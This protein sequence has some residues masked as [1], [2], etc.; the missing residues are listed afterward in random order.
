MEKQ[1]GFALRGEWAEVVGLGGPVLGDFGDV[2]I[3]V[4]VGIG[5]EFDPLAGGIPPDVEV[6]TAAVGAM[7]L[8]EGFSFC[9]AGVED[10]DDAVPVIGGDPFAVG[11]TGGVPPV[12]FGQLA[13][14]DLFDPGAGS[15]DLDV[16]GQEVESFDMAFFAAAF[17][18]V[19]PDEGHLVVHPPALVGG[20]FTGD[21]PEGRCGD[22]RFGVEEPDAGLARGGGVFGGDVAA[23]DAVEG[24]E[25]G[26]CPMELNV[27]GFEVEFGGGEW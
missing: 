25:V 15:F 6:V 26:A 10:G 9:G 7:A 18:V 16:A 5:G 4:A 12:D 1:C 2:D 17:V 11:A 22:A 19:S 14:G 21:L 8:G 13:G 23:V 27:V 24:D 3:G 20:D